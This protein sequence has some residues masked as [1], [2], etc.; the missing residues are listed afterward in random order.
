MTAIRKLVSAAVI[1]VVAAGSSKA[2]GAVYPT[3]ADCASWSQV[4]AGGGTAA[5]QVLSSGWFGGCP[6]SGP[7]ALVQALNASHGSSDTQFLWAL[8]QTAGHIVHPDIFAAARAL[9]SDAAAT[10]SARAAG[11]LIVAAQLGTGLQIGGVTGPPLLAPSLALPSACGPSAALVAKDP[12]AS[13]PLAAAAHRDAAAVIDPIRALVS[14]PSN[15]RALARCLRRAVDP[16][17]PPQINVSGS[18]TVQY[19]CSNRF[20]IHNGTT[21]TLPVAIDVLA[22]GEHVELTVAA[23]S[24]QRFSVGSPDPVRLSY[25]G[26]LVATASNGGTP[27][28]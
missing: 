15:L 26:Q 16:S 17:I 24:D 20:A 27:C 22:T 21:L 11:L 8:T 12:P 14:A 13:L 18:V 6:S 5:A 3:S 19:V 7:A 9:A 25:D 2:Q 4:L 1:L 10:P 28:V 23:G